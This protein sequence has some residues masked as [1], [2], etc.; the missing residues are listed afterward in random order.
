MWVKNGNDALKHLLSGDSLVKPADALY[1]SYWLCARHFNGAQFT[2]DEKNHLHPHAV[3]TVF[4]KS[5]LTNFTEADLELEPKAGVKASTE[6]PICSR[7][8]S[9]GSNLKRHMRTHDEKFI[10]CPLCPYSSTRTDHL[11][12]HISSQHFKE[13][14]TG[15]NQSSSQ[16]SSPFRSALLDTNMKLQR[17]RTIKTTQSP[18]LSIH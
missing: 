1:K 11:R 10:M 4:L 18:I 16:S 13:E 15:R 5:T 14:A 8:Y 12:V 2:S 9:N 3:P 7:L 17:S 6:C